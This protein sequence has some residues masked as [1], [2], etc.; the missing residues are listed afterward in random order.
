[1]TDVNKLRNGT[2]FEL[3]GQPYLVLKYEF[4]KMGRGNANIKLKVRNLITGSVLQKG[5]SSGNN[6]D[7]IFLK[8][9]KM[10]YLFSDQ[11]QSTFMDPVSFEQVEIKNEVLGESKPYLQE[12]GDV[13]VL[14]W[15]EQALAV[16]LPA[17][18]T[19]TIKETGPG[20]KGNTVSNMYKPATLDSG[21]EVKVPLFINQGEK[22]IIDTRNGDYVSRG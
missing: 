15:E 2:A 20:E 6:V 22:V 4:S 5:F 16:E 21:L 18:L 14:F 9:K 10:Q 13:Q 1:M 12:G 19:F 11:Y 17:K 3:D 8:R 7:E